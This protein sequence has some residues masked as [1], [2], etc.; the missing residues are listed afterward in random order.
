[1][2]EYITV[3]AVQTLQTQNEYPRWL[4]TPGEDGGEAIIDPDLG[5]PSGLDGD[6]NYWIR[7][8]GDIQKLN[9]VEFGSDTKS[10]L[11]TLWCWGNKGGI[12]PASNLIDGFSIKRKQSYTEGHCLFLR[13][14]LLHHINDAGKE[15]IWASS[16]QYRQSHTDWGRW[17]EAVTQADRNRLVGYKFCKLTIQAS[18]LDG[19][20]NKATNSR[21]NLGNFTLTYNVGP[22]STRWVIGEMRS[23]ELRNGKGS[24]RVK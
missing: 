14:L 11:N 18:T 19:S 16:F 6:V 4:E 10:G 21:L 5:T 24:I 1:M 7:R 2:I 17:G 9:E 20:G 23:K 8:D 22:A 3:P 12:Y 13:R 15:L